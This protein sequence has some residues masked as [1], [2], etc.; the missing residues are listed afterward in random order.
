MTERLQEILNRKPSKWGNLTVK[1]F[2]RDIKLLQERVQEL[3]QKN[4]KLKQEVDF[5]RVE[6]REMMRLSHENK[7][8]REAIIEALHGLKTL[9]SVAPRLYLISILDKA[10]EREG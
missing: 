9:P 2:E 1:E 7:R 10:L 8:Y 3:E 4:D 6:D 5:W